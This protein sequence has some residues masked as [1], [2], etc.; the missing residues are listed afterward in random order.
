M[1]ITDYIAHI[2]NGSISFKLLDSNK[3]SVEHFVS[4]AW[5]FLKGGPIQ[6]RAKRVY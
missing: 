4:P 1:A 3:N 5:A 2:Q 6:H